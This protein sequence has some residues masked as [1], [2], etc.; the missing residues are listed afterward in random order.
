MAQLDLLVRSRLDDQAALGAAVA[1]LQGGE[2][3]YMGGFGITSVEDGGSEI[4][5]DTLFAYGSITKNICAA[6][7]MRLVEQGQLHLDTPIVEYLPGLRFWK[8]ESYG[9]RVTLRHLLS[10]TSGLPMAGKY[11]GPRDPDSLRRSVY[12]QVAHYAFVAEPGT[13][14]IYSNM[15]YCV[16][17]HVAEAV[18]GR[19]F[20][21]LVQEYVLDPLRMA[22]TTF[23]PAV[24]MTYPL[25]LPHE[26]G[27]DGSPQVVHRMPCNAS[28]HPSSFAFGS[29]SDLA[30]L[31][32][33]YLDQ[34]RFGDEHF[35]APS[36]V[37][38]MQQRH[39][40]LFISSAAHPLAHP[41][42][43]Y[44]L[45]FNVG[46]YRGRRTARHGGMSTGYNCFFDL[47]PDDRAGVV[48][49][50]SYPSEGPLMELVATLYDHALG[51][52]HEGI[53]FLDKPAAI[54]LDVNQ[55]QRYCGTYLDV[56][57]GDIVS[58]VVT[59]EHLTLERKEGL[60]QL[61]PIGRNEFF[62]DVSPTYR[63]PVAFVSDIEGNVVHLVIGGR[64]YQPIELA[65]SF[66][67]DPHLLQSFVGLYRDPTN[68]D[69]ADLLKVDIR[70]GQ[71]RFTEGGDGFPG[72]AISN[73]RF[74]SE[75]GIFEFVGAP[76]GD[77][78]VL[79]RG[80]ATRYYPIDEHAYRVRK[81]TRYVFEVP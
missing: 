80:E 64:P 57:T 74:S 53:V 55:L 18:T 39:A 48:L 35:L 9:R 2:I 52:P 79:V 34:G 54:A 77:A 26:E 25:A 56:G 46:R 75:L 13:V 14:H 1:V 44:G 65:P 4:T 49:L 33:M 63:L 42:G 58:V 59:D 51:V 20:D 60:L 17:G 81:V 76:H 21:G 73:R 78:S 62:A 69:D 32:L 23:D 31:A 66:A 27:P 19:Y 11:W 8:N 47:F 12:E 36:S 29:V 5:P 61:V 38:E 24:A 15:V 50:A 22:R 41:N 7:V 10:H 70:G 68:M 40:S 30:N 72:L 71:L 43:G 37:A 28:G 67:P 6:L 16:A 3:V 45:G